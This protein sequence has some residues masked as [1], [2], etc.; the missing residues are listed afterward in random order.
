MKRLIQ[1]KI[2]QY[3]KPILDGNVKPG[4]HLDFLAFCCSFWSF[5]PTKNHN[6]QCDVQMETSTKKIKTSNKKQKRATKGIWLLVLLFIARFDFFCRC[7]HYKKKTTKQ[8]PK[9]FRLYQFKLLVVLDTL[10][11]GITTVPLDEVY[12]LYDLTQK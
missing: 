7:F 10:L 6:V 4:F 2:P 12:P 5:V 8:K 9:A 11:E 1:R 3:Q